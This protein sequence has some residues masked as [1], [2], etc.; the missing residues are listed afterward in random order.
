MLSRMTGKYLGIDDV[1]NDRKDTWVDCML[2][3][4]MNTLVDFVYVK[5]DRKDTLVDGGVG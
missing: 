1:K 2:Y 4:K 5:D 3:G